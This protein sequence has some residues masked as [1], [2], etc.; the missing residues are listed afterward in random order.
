MAE[1]SE[2]TRQ[3]VYER[4]AH[5]CV[6]CGRSWCLT[7]QHVRARG[8]GGTREPWVNLPGNLITLCWPPDGSGCHPWVEAHPEAAEEGGWSRPRSAPLGLGVRYSDGTWRTLD[9]DGM[10]TSMEMV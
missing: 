7:V 4:D 1:V 3:I 10:F 8:M 2:R 5:R 6:R 9:D